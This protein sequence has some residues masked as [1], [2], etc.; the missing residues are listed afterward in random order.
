MLAHSSCNTFESLC[1]DAV[2]IAMTKTAC[3]KP[4]ERSRANLR[5]LKATFQSIPL[6]YKRLWSP[7]LSA[8]E[9]DFQGLCLYCADKLY[10]VLA[11]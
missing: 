3:T 1:M 11:C 4:L 10:S 6:F 9:A 8:Q 7:P 5:Q 2:D